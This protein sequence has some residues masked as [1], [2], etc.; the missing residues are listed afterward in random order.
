MKKWVLVLSAVL[1]GCGG[2]SGGTGGS[3]ATVDNSWLSFNPTTLQSTVYAGESATIEVMAT[4]SKTISEVLN[5][6]IESSTEGITPD[7]SV[8]PQINGLQ[9]KVTVHVSP[10]LSVGTHNGTLTI[11]LCRD[12]ATTCANPYPGSPW[13]L[14]YRFIVRADSNLSALYKLPLAS[15][16]STYQGNAAH[17]GFVPG[18]LDAT[19]FSRRWSWGQQASSVA[20]E[21]G[22]IF[23][24]APDTSGHWI[25]TALSEASGAILWSQDMGL[26]SKVNPPAVSNGK[27][28]L[29]STGHSDTFMWM[30]DA[31]TGSLLGQQAMSSQWESYLS[32]TVLNGAVY[33]ESGYYGGASKFTNDTL[34]HQWSVALQ[35]YDMWTPAVDAQ[36][37]YAYTGSVFYA[38]NVVDGSVG[39]QIADTNY[40]WAGYSMGGAPVLDGTG[41]V[42]AVQFGSNGSGRLLAFS[43]GQQNILWQKKELF[44]GNPVLADNLLYVV[45][46]QQIE[47]RAADTG[48]V[49]W[50]WI[51][52]E[53]LSSYPNRTRMLAVGNLLFVSA[54]A[55]TY[56][57][58]RTTHATVWQ[59][60]AA[61][62]LAVS[63]NGVLYIANNTKLVAINLH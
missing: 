19:T 52:P 1:A 28:Y 26:L 11:S 47:A 54:E 15:P 25:L 32:P 36:Y 18:S 34:Q 45:N 48:N 9:Y 58:D 10:T 30:F 62:N 14:P 23:S 61:G 6:R 42:F 50:T 29:T 12:A 38:L 5:V 3:N 13:Q 53:T 63:D 27:V 16:W 17:T 31:A 8:I 59:Y 33:T 56:A 2:G 55:N 57:I 43:V 39:F 40:D 51:F 24:T 22:R 37:V 41:R 60:A 21:D 46:G 20:V 44:S 4:S 7:T 35:Q 49:I